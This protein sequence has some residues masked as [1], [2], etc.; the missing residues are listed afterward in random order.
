M[1]QNQKKLPVTVLSGFL[2]AG[3]TTLLKNILLN[4][5]GLRVALIVNDMSEIN[6][7]AKILSS[8]EVQISRKDEKLVEMSNGCICCTLREDLLTEIEN[9]ANQNKYDY[10]I[11]E[12]TGISEP[13]PV[14]E[15]FFFE[16]ESGKKLSNVAQLDTLV[17]VIDAKNFL[18]ELDEAD[19]LKDRDL[20]AGDED[21]RTIADLLVEQVEFAN[22]LVINKSDL[23]SQKELESLKS[24]AKKINSSAKVLTCQHGNLQPDSILNTGLFDI[25]QTREHDEWMKTPLDAKESETEE[26]G[27]SS[28]VYKRRAPFHPERFWQLISNRWEGVVRSKGT[29][30]IASRP[31]LVGVWSQAGGSCSAYFKG[32]WFASL[33]KEDWNFETKEDYEMFQKEWDETFGDRQQEIVLIGRNMDKESLIGDLDKCLLTSM[34]LSKGSSYWQ[35]MGDRFADEEPILEEA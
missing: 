19:Y 4:R 13:M 20:Q 22:V 24:L 15:T 28:F 10:L 9:L 16:D 1:Q 21:T 5:K 34:E 31:D 35:E 11:I 32:Q 23:V 26:F 27:I 29:F 30:W 25:E 6:I 18:N 17:T 3:K 7:D 14:A 12:S 2:G 33:P 8:S